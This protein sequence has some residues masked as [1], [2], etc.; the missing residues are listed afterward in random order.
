MTVLEAV[1]RSGTPTFLHKGA[2]KSA[3]DMLLSGEDVVWAQT[4]NIYKSP[5]PGELSTQIELANSD[6]LPGVLVVT[7]Q[8][9]LFVYN[10]L[11]S[12]SSREIRISDIRSLDTK[13]NFT[14]EVLRIVG[15]SNMI[16]TFAKRQVMA[17]LRNAINAVIAR[18]NAQHASSP[19]PAQTTEDNA[20]DSSDVQQ[21]QSLKQLYDAGVITAEEFAT[22]KAQILGL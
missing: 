21:L 1:K 15:T 17:G 16:V 14:I 3:Q 19:A 6:M 13:A 8:R 12:S 5:I 4:S 11:G 20:L 9:I 7:N 10:I 22:K 18:E 2:I